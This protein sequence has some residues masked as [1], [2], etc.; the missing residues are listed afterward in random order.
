LIHK[1]KKNMI[2]GGCE[3]LEWWGGEVVEL[4]NPETMEQ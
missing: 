1:N 4:W 2:R 3:V